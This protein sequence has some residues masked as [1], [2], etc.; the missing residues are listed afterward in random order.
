MYKQ[1]IIKILARKLH[2]IIYFTSFTIELSPRG[3]E[4]LLNMTEGSYN[5]YFNSSSFLHTDNIHT[6]KST[7]HTIA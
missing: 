2:E 3:S 1:N 4:Y 5:D 6:H 7:E